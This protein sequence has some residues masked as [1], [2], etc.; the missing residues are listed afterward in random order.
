MLPYIALALGRWRSSAAEQRFC[1]PQVG[2]SI[3]LA[4]STTSLLDPT[5]RSNMSGYAIPPVSFVSARHALRR[6]VSA[7]GE[8]TEPIVSQPRVLRG[9]PPSASTAAGPP[10]APTRARARGRPPHLPGPLAAHQ[11]GRTGRE[12]PP[13]RSGSR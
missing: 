1:K 7:R 13:H 6:S 10:T 12:R 11:R 2:G 8:R 4:S 3:P 5:F 9:P